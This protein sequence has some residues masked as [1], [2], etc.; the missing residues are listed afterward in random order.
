MHLTRHPDPQLSV[1]QHDRR[2]PRSPGLHLSHI[3]HDLAATMEPKRFHHDD[4]PGLDLDTVPKIW[5]GQATDHYLRHIRPGVGVGEIDKDGVTMTCDNVSLLGEPPRPGLVGDYA[6][7]W[8]VEEFKL[9]W[10]SPGKLPIE[11]AI[12]DKKFRHWLWQLKGYCWAWETRRARLVVLFVN[13]RYA[14]PTPHPEQL[15]I[16][17]TYEELKNNWAML[18]GHAK[19]RG[20]L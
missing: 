14:P 4:R 9:T 19:K 17:F 7:D 18:L 8:V 1:L 12:Q 3:I 5:L 20:L 10:M 2:D 13:G 6:D 11:Q 16:V 15:D